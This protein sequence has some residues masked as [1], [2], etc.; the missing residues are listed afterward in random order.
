MKKIMVHIFHMDSKGICS[1]YD[2]Y[3]FDKYISNKI[4][5]E[6]KCS[7]LILKEDGS[8][9]PPLARDGSIYEIER[10][11]KQ[12]VTVVIKEEKPAQTTISHSSTNYAEHNAYKVAFDTKLVG[13][14]N[15]DRTRLLAAIRDVNQNCEFHNLYSP[16]VSICQGSGSGKS[17]LACSLDS[18]LACGYVVFRGMEELAYPEKSSLGKMMMA[19]PLPMKKNSFDCTFLSETN[20]GVY[21]HIIYAIVSDYLARV[22]SLK[23]GMGIT[24]PISVS[25]SQQIRQV[26]LREFI[27]GTFTGE[28]IENFEN[29]IKLIDLVK[30]K[31]EE[32]S[33]DKFAGRIKT[34]CDDISHELSLLSATS[35]LVIVLDE[36]HILSGYDETIGTARLNLLRRAMHAL[37]TQS[38]IV[39]VTL[40]TKSDYNDLNPIA[41]TDSMRDCNRTE[42]YPPFIVSRN[43]DIF[44]NQIAKL[45]ISSEMLKDPRMILIRFSMGRPLWCSL[46]IS[47]VIRIA[48]IKLANSSLESGQAFVACWMLRTGIPASPHMV[49]TSRHLLKS[50]MATLLDIHPELPLMN[51]CYPSEP[52]LA[53]A[54]DDLVSRNLIAYFKNLRNH[55]VCKGFDRGD[56]AEVIA[57]EI[58]IEAASNAKRLDISTTAICKALDE[59]ELTKSKKFILE[60]HIDPN[61]LAEKAKKYNVGDCDVPKEAVEHMKMTTLENFLKSLYG[62]KNY[63]NLNLESTVSRRMLN[64]IVNFNHFIRLN[65]NFNFSSILDGLNKSTNIEPRLQKFPSGGGRSVRCRALC[66]LGLKRG[67]AFFAPEHYPGTDLLIP[68][69]LEGNLFI[70]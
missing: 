17:K 67:A 63:E 28:Q 41:A 5:D 38:G 62:E 53:M 35:P 22:K 3:S 58:C 49:E 39:F 50:N 27:E 46:A 11:K 6:K 66:N 29:G 64:G 15:S 30:G 52:V 10:I 68:I 1:F 18:D 12:F 36:V 51:V 9:S 25:Q 34:C 31:M 26:I 24:G 70:Y 60:S 44:R 69:C 48:A 43:T 7:Y 21:V 14:I 40:G 37:G 54:A 47:E 61:I 4:Y 65:T 13:K 23:K 45:S 59:I 16:T 42:I 8:Y 33:F 56:L 20:I 2:K 57:A 19:C 32:L 55:L